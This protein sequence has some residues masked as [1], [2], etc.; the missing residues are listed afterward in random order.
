MSNEKEKGINL[1]QALLECFEHNSKGMPF[2]GCSVQAKGSYWVIDKSASNCFSQNRQKDAFEV[3]ISDG[4]ES[5]LVCVDEGFITSQKSN[6]MARCDH[7]VFAE[8]EF[9]YIEAKMKVQG[10]KWS[11]EINDALTNKIPNTRQYI[12]STLRRNGFDMK[13]KVCIAIPFPPSN[14]RLP[15]KITQYEEQYR[16]EA[17]KKGCGDIYRLILSA[18]VRIK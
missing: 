17:K 10:K 7:F 18:V 9:F 11:D 6:N 1:Y 16:V 8:D 5:W 12:E 2:S 3:Q 15:R 4:K 14:N 13:H